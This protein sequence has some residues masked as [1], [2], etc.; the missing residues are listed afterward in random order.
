M[1]ELGGV[2]TKAL[3]QIEND[4]KKHS[5]KKYLNGADHMTA[6]D[7]FVYPHLIRLLWFKDSVFKALYK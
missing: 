7:V 3:N 6:L 4:L 2:M 5:G 1:Q